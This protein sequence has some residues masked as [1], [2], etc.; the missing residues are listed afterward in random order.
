[1]RNSVCLWRIWV[2]VCFVVMTGHLG[3]VT[4]PAR[5][6]VLVGIDD[7]SATTLHRVAPSPPRDW[8]NLTGAV[9]DVTAMHDL[10]LGAY[11]FEP[12]GIVMLKNQAAT[13]DAILRA[14]D[15]HLLQPAKPGD[16]LLFYFAGHGSLV[17]NSGS[18]EL[19]KLDETIVPADAP[20]G[21]CDIRDKV[22]RHIFNLILDRGARLNVILDSCHSGSGARG[23]PREGHPRGV[24]PGFCDVADHTPP[25][26]LPEE[27][28]ALVLSASQDSEAAWE[29]RD[30]QKKAHG[31]FSWAWTNALRDAA[32]GEAAIDT[33]RRA[34]ARLHAEVPYQDP[35]FAG[36]AAARFSPFLGVRS[37]RRGDKV[38]VAVESVD[39]GTAIVQGGWANGLTI[40]SELRPLDS[41]ARVRL[42]VTATLGLA[43]C[44][45]RING[46]PSLVRSGM[47]LELA[48]WAA[49]PGRPLRIAVFPGPAL[50]VATAGALAEEAARRRIRWVDDPTEQTPTHVLRWRGGKWELLADGNVE[51]IGAALQPAS[52]LR[53]VAPGRTLF[54]QVPSSP[55]LLGAIGLSAAK[56]ISGV[57]VVL[58][59][60]D[61][62]Y[63]LVAHVARGTVEYSWIRP[64]VLTRDQGRTVLP[65]RSDWVSAS[66]GGGAA[67]LLRDALLRLRRIYAWQVLNMPP[68]AFFTYRLG[69]RRSHDGFLMRDKLAAPGPYGLVLRA[70]ANPARVTPRYVYVFAI[71][72]CG[73]SVLL[74]PRKRLG[75]IEN[76]FP[77]AGTTPPVEIRLGTP[78]LFTIKQPYG[79]DTYFLLSTDEALPDPW[80]FEW[81]G[82]QKREPRGTTALA[83]L[84]ELTYDATTRSPAM[85]RTSS[86]W[87]L[88]R[89]VFESLPP[90]VPPHASHAAGSI[91]LAALEPQR[92]DPLSAWMAKI[93]QAQKETAAGRHAAAIALHEDALALLR[94]A[95]ESDEPL[96]L[97]A[98]KAMGP[99]G[100]ILG[101]GPEAKLLK[102]LLLTFAVE[103]LSR[104]AYSGA[105]LEAGRFDDAERE[106][107][108]AAARADLFGFLF[109]PVI[110][111]QFG[112]LR[113]RQRRYDEA[114]ESY[115]KALAAVQRTKSTP[116]PPV[117]PEGLL[118]GK[119]AALEVEAGR[120][121][122]ALAW[123]EKALSLARENHDAAAEASAEADIGALH[124]FR[125]AY[126][127]AAAHLERSLEL[128]QPLNDP[129]ME[130]PVWILL[131][132]VYL[133]T[134]AD[135]SLSS[136]LAKAR[137]LA[138]KSHVAG[139]SEL[140]TVIE[141]AQRLFKG[142]ATAEQLEAAFEKTWKAGLEFPQEA[143]N[144]VRDLIHLRSA[145][146]RV[147]AG[148][149]GDIPLFP[150]IAAVLEGK[151]LFDRGQI[152]A[153]RETWKKVLN[154]TPS[155][156][157]RVGCLGLISA[158]Y[159]RE[160]NAD[161]AIRYF[162]EAVNALELPAEDIRSEEMLAGFLGSERRMYFDMLI[163]MLVRKG[164]VEKAF[165]FAERARARAFLRMIGNQ[166]VKAPSGADSA[167][168]R[169]A[170][171]LRTQIIK[172]E[173]EPV[174]SAKLRD[175]RARYEAL[176]S[177]AQA[178]SPEYASLT[179]IAPLRVDDVRRALPAE[180][181]LVSYFV[182]P[183]GAHAWILDATSF[184]HV[185]LPLTANDAQRI[186]CW[187]ARFEHAGEGRGAVPL[188]DG[189]G[190]AT[191]E[192]AYDALIA[193]L[194]PK[195][196][197]AR[198][199]LI[200][201]G[202]LH[203]VP[204]GAL[205]DRKRG[206]F[207][208]E[209]YTL[210]YA[211]SASSLRFLRAKDAP[212]TASAV[213]LG[214]PASPLGDLP[215]AKREA[216]AVARALGIAAK[217]GA[218]AR[219]SIVY[220]LAGK[221][222]LLH[223]AAHATYDAEHPLFSRVALA[224]GDGEDGN[225]EVHEILSRADFNGVNLVVL[226]ACRSGV[227]RGSGGDE[228]VGLTRALLYAG[229]PGVISTLWSIDD[230]AAAAL[231]ERFYARLLGGAA[232]ADALRGA[233]LQLLRDSTFR[234]PRF[235]AAF[236]LTGDPQGRWKR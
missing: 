38:V 102:P 101:S 12:R 132:D 10:L 200:P 103:P 28:G 99:I 167:L 206:R 87:S 217:V 131:C 42:E 189:C 78:T 152:A 209:D 27:R 71:D 19:D 193:P 77:L 224:K 202:V 129:T 180:T 44:S 91:F 135:E 30:E 164:E 58:R 201:H 228:I 154:A 196:K 230:D 148:S 76:R 80:I 62:D 16:V 82:V 172:E 51:V 161:Q 43:R 114:R 32:G 134:D 221:V 182:S 229:T 214:D 36:D 184:A 124:L 18:D 179:K 85:L 212:V 194:R 119:L 17:L 45:A 34:Q 216:D 100:E 159:W 1:M 106:L 226:S 61:A 163:E 149:G 84:L 110:A 33:F 69:V 151:R 63:L 13:R 3:A 126:G 53:N 2:V 48:E 55:A 15:E 178:S 236:T 60:E 123:N 35:V 121:D 177:R 66:R 81:D 136:A 83:K 187:S 93:A 176:L 68:D 227:G 139:A 5:R 54:V 207:L 108:K 144:V 23:Y 169:E 20:V 4:L 49:P 79:I 104:I 95:A 8:V 50:A 133:I 128:Y 115:R 140:V 89:V 107:N 59:P 218:D 56:T 222:G 191:A 112:D 208:I 130:A 111:M 105:L 170:E 98:F 88:E 204:F 127:S 158:T 14:L 109:E 90:P 120:L 198:L 232:A 122:D 64:A 47:L 225:L 235:W 6:A 37:D 175:D 31:A 213:V 174:P 94:A 147:S 75:T 9:N 205:R 181:T 211:P 162:T 233:Q 234:D 220:R 97:D 150:T 231:M 52:A 86:N 26:K 46:S 138:G 168:V 29:L 210:L 22:L 96:S 40:G 116:F 39:G 141:T 118:L 72:S 185:A 165:D 11:G 186:A 92:R 173:E 70:V 146:P 65:L 143:K 219:E 155:R 192:D 215:G 73:K 199:M 188:D 137:E 183:F 156:D 197:T 25:E 166:R 57:E 203:Y 7:Y 41:A 160:G 74:F 195:I 24:K 67:V 21:A 117:L 153:A 142:E 125:G 157:L 190:A 223:I 145:T 171:A 113:Q